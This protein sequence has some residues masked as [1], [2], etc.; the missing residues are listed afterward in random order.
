M[1]WD[2]KFAWGIKP[3]IKVVALRVAAFIWGFE[4][5]YLSLTLLYILFFIAHIAQKLK[6]GF[7]IRTAASYSDFVEVD[8]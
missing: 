8:A 1:D 6:I 5:S 3:Q 7:I 4:L 2:K